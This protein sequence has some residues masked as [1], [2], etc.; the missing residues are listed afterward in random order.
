MS[1]SWRDKVKVVIIGKLPFILWSP[2]ILVATEV[3]P[4]NASMPKSL[5]EGKALGSEQ[6]KG[7]NSR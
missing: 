3:H 6:N 1:N 7:N 4:K 5:S 2:P